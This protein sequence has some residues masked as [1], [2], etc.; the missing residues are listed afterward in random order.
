MKLFHSIVSDPAPEPSGASAEVKQIL[1]GLLEKEPLQRLGSL[2]GGEQDILE[3]VWF[4]DLDLMAL[5]RRK[6]QAPWIPA[7]KDALDTS[8]FDDWDHL[9]DKM[10]DE[11]PALH[12]KQAAL[13]ADF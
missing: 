12:P 11:T 10:V 8:C 1:S 4:R 7:V 13:F 2:S 9:V 6:E 3:H 5:R